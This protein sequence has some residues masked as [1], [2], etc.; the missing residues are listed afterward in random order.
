[1]ATA[2]ACRRVLGTWLLVSLLAFVAAL[3]MDFDTALNV[4]S[5]LHTDA[6]ATA[7]LVVISLLVV[8]NAAIFSGSYLLGPGFTV[9]TH[10]IV[11]PA[12]VTVGALPMFPLLAAL[13]DTGPTPAWTSGL[14]VVAPLVAA[15]G[16]VRAQRRAPDVPLGG[17]RP[18]R[19]RRRDAGRRGVRAARGPGR[20]R[21]RPGPDERRR[22]AG[23][24]GARARD[25]RVRHR[26]AARR[27][28]R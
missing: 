23:V 10:T 3:V 2:A 12:V 20:R 13:P 21:R 18:A 27:P 1:M 8:P 11:S 4:T 9:G 5:Q 22:S 15:I 7:Q 16:A 24:L 26:R 19:L 28:G 25:H 17:R 14:V 6:G